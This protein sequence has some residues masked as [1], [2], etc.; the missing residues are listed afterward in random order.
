MIHRTLRRYTLYLL[1]ILGSFSSWSLFR[2]SV[3]EGTP[4]E[5]LHKL[6]FLIV[7]IFLF[8]IR[9]RGL[10]VHKFILPF[11]PFIGCSIISLVWQGRSFTDIKSSMTLLIPIILGAALIDGE[12]P[13]TYLHQWRRYVMLAVIL[14]IV[15]GV[16]SSYFGLRSGLRNLWGGSNYQLTGLQGASELAVLTSYITLL[17]FSKLGELKARDWLVILFLILVNLAAG[18][19]TSIAALTVSSL[20]FYPSAVKSFRRGP[21]I[22]FVIMLSLFVGL[23]IARS[24]ERTFRGEEGSTLPIHTSQRFE[25]WPRY[26]ELAKSHL[27]FGSGPGAVVRTMA[28]DDIYAPHNAY[29]SLFLTGGL[30]GLFTYLFGWCSILRTVFKQSK[31]ST[32]KSVMRAV[33]ACSIFIAL[34]AIT[35]G[36]FGHLFTMCIYAGIVAAGVSTH[37]KQATYSKV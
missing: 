27:V 16:F 24:W 3:G 5:S 35:D 33:F 37:P 6:L 21:A 17:Y 26:F 19:R 25:L 28:E 18:C 30:A 7:A 36:S 15:G 8:L 4:I 12:N 20:V 34:F 13:A 9:P 29:L 1:A 23:G 31:T 14:S 32:D 2:P 22:I 11:L 10:G